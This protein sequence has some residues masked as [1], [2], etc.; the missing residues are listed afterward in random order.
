LSFLSGKQALAM[1]PGISLHP[2][3]CGL[4][5]ELIAKCPCPMV[6]DAD[7]LTVVARD[8]P[9]LGKASQ[10]MILTPHPGEMARL[11]GVSAREVQEDR[12][13]TASQF[14]SR[15]GVVLVLKGSGTVV[16]SPDGAVVINSSGTPAMASGGMGDALT[17][18]IAGFL[19]QGFDPFRAAC[20][21][22][23][24]HGAAAER[25]FGHAASRGLLATDVVGEVPP[26]IGELERRCALQ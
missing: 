12:I 14:S 19:G 6:L 11:A 9:V 16:A 26:V 22:V 3:T 10:A 5:M 8:L 2:S 17:G 13:D 23:F 15:H 21:G 18:M 4:V 25:C 7:A 20:L 24:V 1:G